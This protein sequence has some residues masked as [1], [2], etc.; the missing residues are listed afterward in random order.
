MCNGQTVLPSDN[1]LDASIQLPAA[2]IV[3]AGHWIRLAVAFTAYSREGSTPRDNNADLTA[4][5]RRRER[6]SLYASGPTLSV[7]PSTC[8]RRSG[9]AARNCASC[10]SFRLAAGFNSDFPVSNSTS[11]KVK[12]APRGVEVALSASSSACARAASCAALLASKAPQRQLP[13]SSK[14]RPR[15]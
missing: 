1:H 15:R 2:R 7:N 14:A 12:T 3:I 4:S 11:P 9:C 8:T 6:S 10:S 13:D 5:A